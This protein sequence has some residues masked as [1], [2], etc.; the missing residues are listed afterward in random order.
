M[1]ETVHKTR[2]TPEVTPK[3][4]GGRRRER[5]LPGRD[6][7]VVILMVAVPT[8]LVLALVWLPAILTVVLSFGNWNGIGDVSRI[9]WVGFRNYQDIVEIY[10][11]F[12]PAVRHNILWLLFLGVIATPL[13]L[14]IA[15]LLDQRIRGSRIYQTVFFVPVM[16][17]LALVGIIWELMYSPASG[18]VDSLI[19][20]VDPSKGAG[21][22]G[23]IDWLG[24]SNVN[25][26]AAMVAATWR[27]AGYVMILYLAGLKGVDPT[28]REAAAID[29]ANG[30]QTFFRVVFPAMKPTNIIIVSTVGDA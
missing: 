19:G 30:P 27:H 1:S 10:P 14:L 22:P 15:V 16:L 7:L 13:G 12:W 20:L 25:I 26:W 23:A 11:P 24:D 18:L 17:S 3:P 28:L 4:P 2:S 8:L 29:G 21:K 9:Q 5:R 6:R